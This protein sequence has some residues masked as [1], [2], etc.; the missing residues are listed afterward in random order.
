MKK[1]KHYCS[2]AESIA[3]PDVKSYILWHYCINMKKGKRKQSKHSYPLI[4]PLKIL[5]NYKK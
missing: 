3:V 1:V 5:I 2:W 4:K